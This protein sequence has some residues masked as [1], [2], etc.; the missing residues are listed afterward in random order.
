MSLFFK[1]NPKFCFKNDGICAYY[2][3]QFNATL[4]TQLY[5]KLF[6]FK[7]KEIYVLY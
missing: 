1:L 2:S 4:I 6:S 7:A 3:T 5:F